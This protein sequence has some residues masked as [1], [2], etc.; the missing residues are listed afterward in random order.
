MNYTW[1]KLRKI[2][3]ALNI[4]IFNGTAFVTQWSILIQNI[5][6]KPYEYA[7]DI[8]LLIECLLQSLL[9]TRCKLLGNTTGGGGGYPYMLLLSH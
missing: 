3:F 4:N 1:A 9:N 5:L 7:W 2:N 6:Y 8:S